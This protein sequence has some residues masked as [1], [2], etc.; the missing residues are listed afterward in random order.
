MEV[1]SV[2]FLVLAITFFIVMLFDAMF[3]H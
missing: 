2:I 1:F 3:G